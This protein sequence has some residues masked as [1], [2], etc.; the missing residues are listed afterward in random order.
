MAPP[1]AS[2]EELL[3]LMETE[4][5]EYV[6]ASREFL[7]QKTSSSEGTPLSIRQALAKLDPDRYGAQHGES[8]GPDWPPWA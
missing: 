4:G 5:Y 1:I 6:P 7:P 8:P 3:E 2:L